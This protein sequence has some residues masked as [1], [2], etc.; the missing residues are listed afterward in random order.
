MSL[1]MCT[2]V[3]NEETNLSTIEHNLQTLKTWAPG[4]RFLLVDNA[5]QD[6]SSPKL[7]RLVE[8]FGGRYL[9]RSHNHL[10]QARQQALLESETLWVGFIDADCHI[11]ERWIACAKQ[12]LQQN[13]DG[14]AA[15]GGPWTITGKDA[16]IYRVLFRTFWG[17]FGNTYLK[18]EAHKTYVEHLPTANVLYQRSAV[19]AVGGFASSH[20]HVGE[21]LD[22]SHRAYRKGL[23][24]EYNPELKIAH[25]L[26]ETLLLWC[27]KMFLYGTARGEVLVRYKTITS[28]KSMVPVLFLP[29]FLGLW[30]VSGV[31]FVLA[32]CAYVA[33]CVAAVWQWPSI[34]LCGPAAVRMV[35]THVFYALGVCFGLSG[36][37][38]VFLK[39]KRGQ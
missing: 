33:V 20:P 16:P 29:I 12:C 30:F 32:A 5:S 38:Q 34:R 25:R 6:G 9:L 7:Q 39:M 11:D 13:N 2:V 18:Q 26:P 37:S 28:Y 15:I 17:H 1:T 27:Q 8:S 31:Y 22:L 10:P 4:V 14:V 35:S 23:R 24:L 3:Y 21:D 19:L 36:L